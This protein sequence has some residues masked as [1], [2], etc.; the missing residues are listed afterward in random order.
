[1]HEQV[2][3]PLKNP[4]K[5]LLVMVS[6]AATMSCDVLISPVPHPLPQEQDAFPTLCGSGCSCDAPVKTG[7]WQIVIMLI[8]IAVVVSSMMYKEII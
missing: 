5:L 4:A 2:V 6:W 1:M 7:A 3:P 8:A